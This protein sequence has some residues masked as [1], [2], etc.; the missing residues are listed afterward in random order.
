VVAGSTKS[1]G[2]AY[3]KYSG[4][5]P[6]GMWLRSIGL[7]RASEILAPVLDTLRREWPAILAGGGFRVQVLVRGRDYK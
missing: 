7:K 3:I 1:D 5:S 2:L 6:I 4:S